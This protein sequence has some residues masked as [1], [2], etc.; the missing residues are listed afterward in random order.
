M[1]NIGDDDATEGSFRG[2]WAGGNE[3]LWVL[4]LSSLF[5]QVFLAEYVENTVLSRELHTHY[6]E[7]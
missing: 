5:L 1:K 3:V 4:E 6:Y 2:S 7:K